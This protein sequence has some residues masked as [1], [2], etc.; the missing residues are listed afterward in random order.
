MCGIFGFLLFIFLFFVRV[1]IVI[2][3]IINE[4]VFELGFFINVKVI[5][6]GGDI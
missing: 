4:Y 1:G 6:G 2:G 5:V 3:M